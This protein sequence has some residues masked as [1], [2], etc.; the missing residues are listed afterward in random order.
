M[1]AL[2]RSNYSAE[3]VWLGRTTAG[4]SLRSAAVESLDLGFDGIAGGRHQGAT[5]PSCSRVLDLHPRDTEIRN[6]RQLTMLDAGDLAAIAELVGLASLDPGL[7]GASIVV[8]GIPDLSHLPPSSRLQAPS[9]ATITVDMENRPCIFP[10]REIEAEAPGHGKGF[11]P[12]AE[13]RRGI[14]AWVERPGRLA[15]GD[16]LSLFVPDQPA[17]T[18]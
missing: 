18:P 14:T 1:P 10:G 7:L 17:W 6:T 15:L 9:G 12:A 5:R 3:I 11:K 8:T 2:K 16:R 13:G 4:G